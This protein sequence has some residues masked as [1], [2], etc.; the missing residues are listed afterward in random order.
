[1]RQDRRRL[2]VRSRVQNIGAAVLAPTFS[3]LDRSLAELE[4]R[5]PGFSV[6]LTGTVVVAARN[7]QRDDRGHSPE[8]QHGSHRYL[9][10][11]DSVDS[12][13]CDSV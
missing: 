5:Y 12:A 1:M 11:D 7:L 6:H 9:R 10:N 2:V 13:H 3:D 8:S 4:K